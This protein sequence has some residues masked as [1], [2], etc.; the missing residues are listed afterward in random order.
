MVTKIEAARIAMSAGTNMVIASGKVLHPLRQ[1]AEGCPSTW[2]LAPTDPVA[3][4]K[5]WI[6]G[7][8]E[9]RGA[10]VVDTGAAKALAAGKSLLPAGVVRV[11]G[12]FERGDCVVIRSH[13]GRDL[14]RGLTAY[15]AADAARILGR[16]SGEIA[17]ILGHPGRSEL[18][19]RD[20]MVLAR[21]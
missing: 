17:E 20:D 21:A 16:K 12:S 8:L 7:Q 13:D 18:V 11:E 3:A 19:H 5:R 9:P 6:A 2:F 1:L 4:R 14:G 10:I 15:G